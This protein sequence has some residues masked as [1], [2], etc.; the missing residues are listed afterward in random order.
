MHAG[1]DVVGVG[2]SGAKS[3]PPA[4]TIRV[5]AADAPAPTLRARICRIGLLLMV[6]I[7]AGWGSRLYWAGARNRCFSSNAAEI[8]ALARE[9]N[10]DVWLANDWTTLPIAA[11]LAREK[12]GR[13]S[14]DTHEFAVEEHAES[15]KWRFLQRPMVRAVEHELISEAAVVSAVSKGIAERLDGLYRLSRPALAIRNTPGF[16]EVRF[17]ATQ[18]ERIRVLYHGIVTPNRGL[19]AA[20]DSVRLWRR[21]FTLTIRGPETAGFSTALRRRIRDLG[22]DDRVCLAPAMPMTELV[23]AASAFDIGLFALPGHSRHNQ[24]ALPN[25]FFEYITAGLALCVSD[26]PEMARLVRRYRLGELIA[27]IDPS[28][29]AAAIN[30]FDSERIDRCK[31]N[32]LSAAGELCWE[33]ES[34]HLVT[35]YRNLLPEAAR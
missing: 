17:R 2:L 5:C 10:A 32:S 24:L 16:E 19:E 13:Y 7:H 33:R 1:W 27:C 26:L 20:I 31:R 22:L 30:A 8:F 12:G 34:A 15:L 29:I 35:A 11:R 21:Q 14:Y 18:A 6:R 25:K 4:W 28:A 9:I 23:K 3:S